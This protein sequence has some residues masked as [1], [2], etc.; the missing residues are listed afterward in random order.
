[1]TSPEPINKTTAVAD[2]IEEAR[3]YAEMEKSW[4]IYAAVCHAFLELEAEHGYFARANW[5]CCQTCGVAAIPNDFVNYVFYHEQDAHKLREEGRLLLAWGGD[6]NLIVKV[7]Q[8]H[9]LDVEWDGS[10]RHRILITGLSK[11]NGK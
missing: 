5:W 1:M 9:G 10:D 7:L 11:W 8:E 6:G 2:E 3:L 4:Q